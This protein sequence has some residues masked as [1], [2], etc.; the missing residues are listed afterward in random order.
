MVARPRFLGDPIVFIGLRHG[1][2]LNY[3]HQS[4]TKSYLQSTRSRRVGAVDL[5]LRPVFPVGAQV[6]KVAF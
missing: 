6:A 3:T 2:Q 4:R 5:T 1:E